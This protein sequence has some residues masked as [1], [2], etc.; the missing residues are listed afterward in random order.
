MTPEK[1][2]QN[3]V[4]RTFATRSDM[5]LWRANT[6]VARMGDRTVRFGVPG[7]ADLSGIL[8][9]GTRLEIECKA[10]GGRQSK[11]QRNWQNIIER[12][13]G[14]YVLAYSVGDVWKAI[15]RF[16]DCGSQATT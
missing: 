11:D 8:R 10:P 15:G 13:G 7:Q 6:G 3:E 4:L 12:F 9:G 5:R 2:F 16:L 14:I 1:L